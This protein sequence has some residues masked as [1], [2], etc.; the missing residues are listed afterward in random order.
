MPPD[1]FSS[2][3]HRE[4]AAIARVV[5]IS[6]GNPASVSERCSAAAFCHELPSPHLP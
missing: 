1:R 2:F 5:A 4:I 3:S 6:C